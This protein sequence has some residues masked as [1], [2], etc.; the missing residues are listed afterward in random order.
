MGRLTTHVLDTARGEPAAGM[1]F[2]LSREAQTWRG[3][4]DAD[5]RALVL[6]GEAFLAGTYQIVF[7]VGA[8]RGGDRGFYEEVPVRF[9]VDDP[10]RHVHVPL[11][12]SPFGYTTYRGS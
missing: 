5:G 2:E 3:V 4:T 11:L 7:A 8:W 12:I 9:C 10:G 6:E 1:A